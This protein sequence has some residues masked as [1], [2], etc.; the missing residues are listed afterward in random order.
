[1]L[2]SDKVEIK[3]TTRN[4]TY[5]RNKGYNIPKISSN[6][7]KDKNKCTS[8]NIFVNIDDL[9]P[10][11]KAL[12]KRECDN[13]HLVEYVPYYNWNNRKYKEFGDLCFNCAV[14]IKLPKI[15]MEKYGVKNCAQVE[16]VSN[17]KKETNLKRYGNEWAIASNEVRKSIVDSFIEK[18]GVDNPMK[19]KRIQEKTK[20][21]NI[22]KYGGNSPMCNEAVREKS[23]KTCLNKYG[24]DNPF[25]SKDIQAK[26]R[27]ML[28]KNNSTPSS[29]AEKKLC[30]ILINIFGEK[31]C[32]PNYPCG[33][34]SLDCLLI[35][36]GNKIDI[37]YDGSYWHKDRK[38][39]DGA[40]NAVLINNGY[41][42]LRIKGNNKDELPQIKEIISS[43]DYLINQNHHLVFIDM[44]KKK[45]I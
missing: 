21:T 30:E 37:E 29:K 19:N 41:K 16:N 13:C 34:L 27:K 39:Y 15:M 11:S 38:Q 2:L 25:K 23:I 18:Y 5:Y 32:F 26:A 20:K 43:I 40:R 17:K 33:N 9:S 24:V 12:V 6:N 44:N 10:T 45:N 35:L 14:K 3:I 7:S 31:N 42:I 4:I 1:M 36:N 8:F 22:L 28:Y